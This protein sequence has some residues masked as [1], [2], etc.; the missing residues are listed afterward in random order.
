MAAPLPSNLL[1]LFYLRSTSQARP[2]LVAVLGC[3]GGGLLAVPASGFATLPPSL[4]AQITTASVQS[5]GQFRALTARE[6]WV[7][8]LDAVDQIVES[9]GLNDPVY[10]YSRLQSLVE[11][12]PGT[13]TVTAL[14][15]PGRCTVGRL[16]LLAAWEQAVATRFPVAEHGETYVY[17]LLLPLGPLQA[18]RHGQSIALLYPTLDPVVF[19]T[20]DN[21]VVLL[22]IAYE[23]LARLQQDVQR[24]L[25]VHSFASAALPVP[26]RQR[27]E[28][29]LL[30]D[31]YVIRGDTAVKE[32]SPGTSTNDATSFLARLRSLAQTWLAPQLQL[33]PQAT[34]KMYQ[35]ILSELLPAISVDEDRAMYTALAQAVELCCNPP[36]ASPVASASSAGQPTTQLSPRPRTTVQPDP[37]PTVKLR[38]TMSRRDIWAADFGTPTSQSPSATTR[39]DKDE[40]TRDTVAERSTTTDTGSKPQPG[41]HDWAEDFEAPTAPPAKPSTSQ[42][43]WSDDFA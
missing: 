32:A 26:S 6:V 43:D 25:P 1:D 29:D 21:S 34:P 14:D 41:Q 9:G 12:L 8:T 40:W 28:A 31:G 38:R 33:P 10:L 39:L 17:H 42:N 11:A 30:A 22:R 24:E 15:Q 20:P 16:D 3:L 18:V 13:P 27:L 35:A 5:R 19:T 2:E 36:S 37:Q 4:Q 7:A 23:V